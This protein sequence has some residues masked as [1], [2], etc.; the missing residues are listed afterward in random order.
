MTEIEDELAK[1]WPNPYKQFR[2]PKEDKQSVLDHFS[3][4]EITVYWDGVKKD[5]ILCFKRKD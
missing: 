5:Y 4:W 2:V 3:D 1:E